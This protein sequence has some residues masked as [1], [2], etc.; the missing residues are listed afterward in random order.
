MIEKLPL[1]GGLVNCSAKD[2]LEAFEELF[3][4]QFFSLSPIWLWAFVMKI[5][6]QGKN[7]RLADIITDSVS[8]GELFLYCT[9]IL[10]PIFYMALSERKTSRTFPN[11]LS[12]IVFVVTIISLSSIFFV[13][14]RKGEPFNIQNVFTFSII[15]YSVSLLLIYIATVYKNSLLSPSEEFQKEEKDFVNEFNNHRR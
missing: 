15:F 9:S 3:L 7:K 6:E 4:K 13:L 8:H 5:T 14:N 12:H 11:K 1:I 2:F 10:A